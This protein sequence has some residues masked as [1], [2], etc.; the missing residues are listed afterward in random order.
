MFSPSVSHTHLR[1]G[2]ASGNFLCHIRLSPLGGDC[3]TTMLAQDISYTDGKSRITPWWRLL[4]DTIATR[5]KLHR[6]NITEVDTP[7]CQICKT[8]PEDLHHFFDDC[9]RK[10]LFWIEALQAFELYET[11]PTK[12]SIWTALHTLQSTPR[13]YMTASTI[14]RLGSIIAILWRYHWQCVLDNEEWCTTA[15]LN[16]LN[17]HILFSSSLSNPIV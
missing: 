12:Q 17:S 6:W 7:I 16:L 3:Y 11:F 2:A 15:V 8:H 10:R 14:F 13:S 5:Q 4:H 1:S 9:P